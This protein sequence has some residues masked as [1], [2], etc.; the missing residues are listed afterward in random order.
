MAKAI[1]HKVIIEICDD[2]ISAELATATVDKFFR[3]APRHHIHDAMHDVFGFDSSAG[4]VWFD[5]IPNHDR[6]EDVFK[7]W[8]R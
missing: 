8:I 2:R 1:R 6:T 4:Q 5:W 3:T 7:L